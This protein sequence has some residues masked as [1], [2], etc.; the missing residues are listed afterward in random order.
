MHV[1]FL[2]KVQS[3]SVEY[4]L[5]ELLP[6]KPAYCLTDHRLGLHPR[7]KFLGSQ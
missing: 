2:L 7:I 6:Y 5:L 1:Y 3:E 4:Q